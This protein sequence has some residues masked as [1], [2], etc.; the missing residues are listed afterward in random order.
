MP[1]GEMSGSRVGPVG[2]SLDA[3][4]A[5]EEAIGHGGITSSEYTAGLDQVCQAQKSLERRRA[6]GELPWMDLPGIDPSPYLA[7]AEKW[8]GRFDNLLVLGIGGSALGTT[9]LGTALLHP[10]HNV[11]PESAR[12]G[13]P[14]LFVLDNVDPDQTAALFDILDW[15]RTLVSVVSKSG[16]TAE[17]AAAYLM[18]RGMLQE[19]PAPG[20]RRTDAFRRHLVF[21]TDPEA[22]VLREIGR[23]EGITMF[24]VPPGVGGRFSVLSA[25]GL[26]PAALCGMDVPS[27]LGGAQA[28]DERIR[29]G[30]GADNPA[31][32]YAL[33]QYLEYVNHGRRISVMMPYSARLRDVADWYRQLWAESLGKAV[34]RNGRE[35]HVGATPVKALGATDQHSQVQLYA[36]GP[37]DKVVCFLRVGR[38]DRE[39]V[40]PPLHAEKD[41][42][43]YLGG[44]DLG[45]LLNAEQKATAWA[46]AQRGRP[47][48]RIDVPRVNARHVGELIF[49]LEYATA[50]AGE[51]F[52]VDAFDQPGVEL[53]KRATYALMGRRGYEE[54]ARQIE[55]AAG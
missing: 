50:L 8:R 13:R 18:A 41:S 10:Y 53:G 35:L 21:T 29:D 17:T 2:V 14:R 3:T 22:G 51:L 39:A 24:D 16:S 27:L 48:V 7:F 26:L 37:D 43:G 30:A 23:D 31:G 38:F 36:E 54:L 11:L 49:M 44:S 52:N 34:D 40:V 55:G 47:S 25:V 12:E 33:I 19:R 5:L 32:A 1:E 15:K 20:E 4:L 42:L 6:A 45:S 28:M 9:A 46:L